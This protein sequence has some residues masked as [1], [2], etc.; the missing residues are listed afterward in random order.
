[1]NTVRL[2]DEG[3]FAHAL[4]QATRIAEAVA[5]CAIAVAVLADEYDRIVAGDGAAKGLP[6]S[7]R[8]RIERESPTPVR[9]EPGSPVF[10]L[11]VVARRLSVLRQRARLPE[12]SGSLEP[13]PDW[14]VTRLG[15]SRSVRL[16]L[17]EV[18][19]FRD[20]ALKLGKIP[21]EQDYRGGVGP[22]PPASDKIDFDK[23]WADFIDLA[24][25]THNRLLGSTKVH[26]LGWWAS[27]ASREHVASD[28]A[29]VSTSNLQGQFKTPVI[30][31]R[32]K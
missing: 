20:K 24:P 7:D 4:V 11:S 1:E 6:A 8:D 18:C 26:L 17:S 25:A 12:A 29:Q 10:L 22:M 16:T 21:T 14:L 32:L 30:D 23:L 9:L 31:I 5:N 13:L 28:P 19:S 27:E 3:L 2:G 15:G